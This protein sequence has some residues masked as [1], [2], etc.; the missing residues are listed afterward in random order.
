MDLNTTPLIDVMLVLLVM[1]I[2]TVPIQT[3]AVK[4]DLPADCRS[5]PAPDPHVNT[6][7]IS[8][9]D[10]LAWNGVPIAMPQLEPM[11]RRMQ[12]MQ[13]APELHLRPDPQAHYETVDGV[14][15][16]IKR[17]R[18]R[19]FGFVGNEAYRRSF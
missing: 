12:Q 14:L 13:P 6:L 5:C 3:H 19:R 8:A 11:L 16:S 15:A 1:F 9:S 4:I 10:Q 7:S 2:I 17:E 18:V